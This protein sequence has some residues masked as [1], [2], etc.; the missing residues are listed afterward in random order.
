[1]LNSAAAR[2]R[3]HQSQARRS[4]ASAQGQKRAP[5]ADAVLALKHDS[6]LLAEATTRL[7]L[8]SCT[9]LGLR[10]L[11]ALGLDVLHR[12]LDGVLRGGSGD[13]VSNAVERTGACS[14]L[15]YVG[16]LRVS[17]GC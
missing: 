9:P 15:G 8:P 2:A 12:R 1:M 16:L 10:L 13:G 4:S 17:T 5:A 7:G 11:G 14:F 3:T 6:E